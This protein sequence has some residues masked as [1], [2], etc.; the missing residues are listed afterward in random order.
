MAH[1]SHG[2]PT[3]YGNACYGVIRHFQTLETETR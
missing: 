3:L 2:T 1:I